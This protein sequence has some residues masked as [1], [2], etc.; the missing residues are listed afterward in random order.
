MFRSGETVSEYI[1]KADG[2]GVDEERVKTHGVELTI[3]KIYKLDGVAVIE[4]GDYTKAHRKELEAHPPDEASDADER[5]YKLDEGGYVVKYNERITIPENHVGFTLPRSRLIRNNINLAAAV[6]DSGYQ[7][8][9]E[10]GLDVST[11]TLLQAD[12]GIAQILFSRATTHS[13]YDGLHNNEE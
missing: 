11:T 7:G 1:T 9:G 13:Q 5:Y 3:D 6:W 8:R 4:E 12:I 2:S 10:G